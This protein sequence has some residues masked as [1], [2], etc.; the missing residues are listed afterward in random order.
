MQ[1]LKWRPLGVYSGIPETEDRED[2]DLSDE[3]ERMDRRVMPAGYRNEEA[4]ESDDKED[5]DR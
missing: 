1:L 2:S 3:A 5:I 4:E